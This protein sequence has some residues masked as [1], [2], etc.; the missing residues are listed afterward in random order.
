MERLAWLVCLLIGDSELFYQRS[1]SHPSGYLRCFAATQC[2]NLPRSTSATDPAPLQASRGSSTQAAGEDVQSGCRLP[3]ATCLLAPPPSTRGA[4]QGAPDQ[5]PSCQLNQ[6]NMA[7]SVLLQAIDIPINKFDA[8][9]NTFVDFRFFRRAS[10]LS[11]IWSQKLP[12]R[13]LEPNK[14]PLLLLLV[15]PSHC[16]L[17]EHGNRYIPNLIRQTHDQLTRGRSIDVLV[18]V[19]DRISYP[20][21]LDSPKGVFRSCHTNFTALGISVLL[22]DSETAAPDLWSTRQQAKKNA[23]SAAQVRNILSFHFDTIPGH[24]F[25]NEAASDSNMTIKLPV[26]N[27]LF[28][29]GQISTIEAQRWIVGETLIEPTLACTK[30]TQLDQQCIRLTAPSIEE[31]LRPS[32][33][34]K[35]P[36]SSITEP[37]V[38]ASA[39]GNVVR[40]VYTDEAFEEVQPASKELEGAVMHWLAENGKES[41]TV[42]VWAILNGFGGIADTSKIGFILSYG[43]RVQRVLSG[44]GGWGNKQG[45]LALDPEQDFNIR[46]ELSPVEGPGSGELSFEEVSS[47]FGHQPIRPREAIRFYVKRPQIEQSS[48][49][50]RPREIYNYEPTMIFGTTPSTI[51]AMPPS[52][53]APAR[54]STAQPCLFARGHFGMRSENGMTLRRT[55]KSG[56]PS[57]TKIDVPQSSISFGVSVNIH[58]SLDAKDMNLDVKDV[59]DD[60]KDAMKGVRVRRVNRGMTRVGTKTGRIQTYQPV[61]EYQALTVAG[62]EPKG[63]SLEEALVAGRA[64]NTASNGKGL[65]KEIVRKVSPPIVRR[66]LLPR[67]MVRY[68]QVLG[69]WAMASGKV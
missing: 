19:V 59:K 45:L 28:H 10:S 3:G 16:R 27:T 20:A 43:A 46:S 35:I 51:D 42:D 21:Y 33:R 30:I 24:P 61:S 2:T 13:S 1:K 50:D 31:T 22:L 32:F 11:P 58:G 26:A 65:R 15:T 41:Q 56:L 47:G 66:Y 23:P 4:S 34:L 67:T 36:L 52:S 40:E 53:S 25:L 29:N 37:R 68:H 38:V 69:Q 64:Q 57:Q 12:H 60:G 49:S 54:D 17:I 44:G 62:N 6:P 14:T 5:A 63:S 9:G 7:S 55:T 39:M 18:A 48:T 8:G